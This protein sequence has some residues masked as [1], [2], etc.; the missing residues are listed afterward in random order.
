MKWRICGKDFKCCFS[1]QSDRLSYFAKQNGQKICSVIIIGYFG[2]VYQK[3]L[4][5][6]VI[7]GQNLKRFKGYK[8]FWKALYILS[9]ER[10]KACIQI[11]LKQATSLLLIFSHSSIKHAYWQK[12][13]VLMHSYSCRISHHTHT[14][15]HTHTAQ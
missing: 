9:V 13:N 10:H 1:I 15:T 5:K 7:C 12:L 6:F 3:V 8:Y 2:E 4:I 14:H 11:R